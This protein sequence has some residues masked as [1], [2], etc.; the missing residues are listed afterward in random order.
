[1]KKTIGLLMILAAF[2]I[3]LYKDSGFFGYGGYF[4]KSW[5]NIIICVI[6]FI[7]G[8]LLIKKVNRNS[9]YNRDKHNR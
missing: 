6:L 5:E 7:I 1:M 2:L 8:F 4:D 9:I 3:L